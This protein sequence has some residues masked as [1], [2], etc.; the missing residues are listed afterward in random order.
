[1]IPS[2]TVPWYTLPYP[3]LHYP[4]LTV[5]SV[6]TQTRILSRFVILPSTLDNEASSGQ[7]PSR[8]VEDE[9]E[10]A[11]LSDDEQNRRNDARRGRRRRVSGEGGA[12]ARRSS[13]QRR[14]AQ[15]NSPDVARSGNGNNLWSRFLLHKRLPLPRV[16]LTFL[17]ICD[18]FS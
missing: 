6:H 3:T 4:V 9:E 16:S 14:I 15:S 5:L 18:H 7:A 17:G 12:N 13:H 8:E 11:P 2:R 10:P 1:M